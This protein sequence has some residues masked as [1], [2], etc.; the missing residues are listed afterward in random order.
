MSVLLRFWNS[1]NSFTAQ[2]KYEEA[3][4]YY[5]R[6]LEGSDKALGATHPRTLATAKNFAIFLDEQGK[7]EDA[8]QLKS[9]YNV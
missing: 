1:Q 5:R 7:H 3:E 2:G 8:R 4:G 6:T 9:K